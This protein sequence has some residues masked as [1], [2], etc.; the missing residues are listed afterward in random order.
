MPHL[1]ARGKSHRFSR[2]AAGVV[3]SR[4]SVGMA[5]PNS[6]LFCEVRT[7]A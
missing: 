3:Y 5:I 7:P 6:S 4:F 1:M 2:G